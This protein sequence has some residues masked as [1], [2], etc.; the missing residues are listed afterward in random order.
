MNESIIKH[1]LYNLINRKKY[2][3]CDFLTDVPEVPPDEFVENIKNLMLRPINIVVNCYRLN[4]LSDKWMS[5]FSVLHYQLLDLDSKLIFLTPT[6][7]LQKVFER[8][9]FK[10]IK[11]LPSLL[12]AIEELEIEGEEETKLNFLKAFI[13]GTIRTLF[14]QSNTPS[15]RKKVYLKKATETSF[16]SECSGYMTVFGE[17]FF[18]TVV[19]SFNR[20]TIRNVISSMIGSEL[21]DSDSDLMDGICEL[22]NIIMGQTKYV[23]VKKGKITD[24]VPIVNT[25]TPRAQMIKDYPDTEVN[26]DG[27]P[28][29]LFG[30]GNTVVVPCSSVQGDFFIEVWVPREHIDKV[31]KSIVH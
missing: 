22:M 24:A 10:F 8:N 18:Y 15:F 4:N 20:S 19:I 5:I 26:F 31:M 30:R 6:K 7:N 12:R 17:N 25:T 11:T 3:V 27:K 16:S 14:I 28:Y 21:P 29:K 9:E 13:Y 1:P 23:L 2:I